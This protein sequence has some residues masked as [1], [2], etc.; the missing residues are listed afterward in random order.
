MEIKALKNS[1]KVVF[2]A[3]KQA[4]PFIWGLHGTGKSQVIEQICFENGWK[5]Q[6]FRLN[7]M[8]DEGDIIGLQDFVKD[9]EGNSIGVS[10]VCPAYIKEMFDFCKANPDK[11]GVLFFDEVNRPSRFSILG[12]LFQ[13]TTARRLHLWPFPENLHIVLAGNPDTEDY[14]VLNIEDKALLDRFIHIKFEPSHAEF[15][16]YADSKGANATLMNFFKEQPNQ[17]ESGSLATFDVSSMAQPSR[18]SIIELVNPLYERFLSGEL[19]RG[20]FTELCTGILG[21]DA[22]SALNSYLANLKDHP[23]SPEDLFKKKPSEMKRLKTLTDRIDVLRVTMDNALAALQEE[24]NAT[25]K[26]YKAF[27]D[28]LCD[29]C[30][31]DLAINCLI[32]DPSNAEGNFITGK[33]FQKLRADSK[34]YRHEDIKELIKRKNAT[35]PA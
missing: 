6:D 2:N 31:A 4:V 17:I 13:I 18:R 7:L 3:S 33:V 23:V 26:N 28:Y 35:A 15:F 25:V 9:K 30:P 11:K 27:V 21:S 32:G 22:V 12:V 16:E 19:S 20:E 10:H 34:Q 14:S 5:M 24:G 8:A 29:F 1:I